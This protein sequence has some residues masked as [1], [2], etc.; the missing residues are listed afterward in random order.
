MCVLRE[1]YFFYS[2]IYVFVQDN[3]QYNFLFFGYLL[4][5]LCLSKILRL[6]FPRRTVGFLYKIME[7]TQLYLFVGCP[8]IV[9]YPNDG[10]NLHHNEKLG[11][12]L[13]PKWPFYHNM[14]FLIP[15]LAFVWK[16][17]VSPPIWSR[18]PFFFN[19]NKNFPHQLLKYKFG[20][21]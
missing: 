18:P 13:A 9:C 5:N 21:W 6:F 1:L 17:Q 7:F 14:H 3:L 8:N 12:S 20:I 10:V 2:C 16:I 4:V 11:A 15:G 19:K